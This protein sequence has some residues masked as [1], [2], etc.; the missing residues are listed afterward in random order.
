MIDVVYVCYYVKDFDYGYGFG[1]G[2]DDVVTYGLDGFRL[3]CDLGGFLT[4][5]V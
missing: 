3:N 5:I 4:G 2:G 1:Y